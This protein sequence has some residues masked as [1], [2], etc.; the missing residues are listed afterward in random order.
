[1]TGAGKHRSQQWWAEFGRLLAT[2][3]FVDLVSTASSTPISAPG[4]R[5]FTPK[6]TLVH[7]SVKGNT[8]LSTTHG[9]SG[10]DEPR[11]F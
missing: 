6:F 2:E 7:L 4:G 5:S 9:A 11:M 8:W 10:G 1:M 3:G